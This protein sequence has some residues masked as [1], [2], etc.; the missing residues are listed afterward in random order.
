MIM[1]RLF[2][3]IVIVAMVIGMTSC[4]KKDE[5]KITA[6]N[7]EAAYRAAGYAVVSANAYNS[8]IDNKNLEAIWQVSKTIEDKDVAAKIYVFSN[9]DAMQTYWD[10]WTATYPNNSHELLS[11]S[12]QN[13]LLTEISVNDVPGTTQFADGAPRLSDD[14][15]KELI[16]VLNS[17][18]F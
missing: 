4:A 14:L 16:S 5:G 11:T 2:S 13:A 15:V 10:A 1:K 7:V 17:I 6:A 8:K 3:A 18:K 12:R 9:T